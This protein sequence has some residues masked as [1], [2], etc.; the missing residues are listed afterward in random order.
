M[1]EHLP[2]EYVNYSLKWAKET[3]SE[4]ETLIQNEFWNTAINRLYYACFYAVSAFLIKNG[5]ETSSHSGCRQKIG[6]QGILQLD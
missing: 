6:Q 2:N 4:V 5:I 1:S 3:I